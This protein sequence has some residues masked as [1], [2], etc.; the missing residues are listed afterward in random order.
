V[1]EQIRDNRLI[2]PSA[3][4]VGPVGRTVTAARA[5]AASP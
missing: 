5:A 2:R 4:Y 3:D 1:L